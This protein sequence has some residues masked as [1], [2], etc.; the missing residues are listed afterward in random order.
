MVE[1]RQMFLHD[2]FYSFLPFAVSKLR[3]VLVIPILTKLFGPSTYGVWIQYSISLILIT[4]LASLGLENAMNRYLPGADDTRLREDYYAVLVVTLATAVA[5]G[6][7]T[8]IFRQTTAEFLFPT[9]SGSTILLLL[10]TASVANIY[11]VQTLQMLRS[12]RRIKSMNLWRS[13]RILGEVGCLLVGGFFL[14]SIVG[15]FLGI[16]ALYLLFSLLLS[17]QAV[18]IVGVSIPRFAN[19]RSYLNFSL[20]LLLSTVAYWVVNTSDRYVIT[21]FLGLDSVGIYSVMYAIAAVIGTV[22]HPIINVLFPDL[23]ELKKEGET[24]ESQSRLGIIVRYFLLF[25]TPSIVGI[26]ILRIPTIRLI[27]TSTI[28]RDAN[29]MAILAPGMA[30]Y[31]TFNIFIQVLKVEER[32]LLVGLLWGGVAISNICLNIILVPVYG[33]T[34]AAIATFTAFVIGLTSAG[35]YLREDLVQIRFEFVRVVASAGVMGV[36][37]LIMRWQLSPLGFPSLFATVLV[38]IGIYTIS[39]Y[40]LRTITGHELKYLQQKLS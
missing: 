4:K 17:V 34:G 36:F 3:G 6:L 37:V 20:P 31:G 7:F 13:A 23:S 27:S 12:Q 9:E 38:G 40:R 11:F 30:L 26:I 21:Y 5:I 39:S 25:A 18:S 33:I 32:T 8:I 22:S 2:V 14:N 29:L 35:W 16:L 15:V 10:A 1:S 24:E 28:A 19:I